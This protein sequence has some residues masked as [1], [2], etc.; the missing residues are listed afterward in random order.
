AGGEDQ[1]SAVGIGPVEERTDDPGHV[2]G[3]DIAVADLV[4][5]LRRPRRDGVA[6]DVVTLAA[7]ARVRDREDRD[8]HYFAF[9]ALPFVQKGSLT[10]S[11]GSRSPRHSTSNRVP[12]FAASIGR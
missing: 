10:T 6:R 8:A 5:P 3:D 1:I 11:A 2:I 9:F 7:T 4:S 12:A